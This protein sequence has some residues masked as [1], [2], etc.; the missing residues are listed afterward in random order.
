MADTEPRQVIHGPPEGQR[1]KLACGHCGSVRA[2]AHMVGA[3]DPG[4]V[5]ADKPACNPYPGSPSYVRSRLVPNLLED[6][7][8]VDGLILEIE[9]RQLL[10]E[11]QRSVLHDMKNALVRWRELQDCI[12][13]TAPIAP[14]AD[15]A[16]L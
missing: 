7:V 16:K 15:N 5:C 8:M 13:E 14:P 12:A 2:I 9:D 11:S 1:V 3:R 6:Q 4:L 10:A